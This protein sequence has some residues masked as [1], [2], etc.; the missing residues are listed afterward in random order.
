VQS[1]T[2]RSAALAGLDEPGRPLG[3]AAFGLAPL[4]N[5]AHALLRTATAWPQ[6]NAVQDGRQITNFAELAHRALGIAAALADAGVRP[7]DRVGLYLRRS[8]DAAAAFFGVLAAGAVAVFVNETLRPRQIGY[9]VRHVD[10]QILIAADDLLKRLGQPL[11]VT[12]RLLDIDSLPAGGT[13][14]PVTRVEGDVAQ[15]IF[16]SGSTG[17]PKGVTLSHGNLWAGTRS[18]VAYLGIDR[19]DKVASLLPFSFDYGLN[20]LLCC[21]AT[22]ATLVIERAVVPQRIVQSLRNAEATVLAAVPPLWLQLLDVDDFL[23][24]PLPALRAMTNTGGHLPREAVRKLRAV[25]PQADLVLMYGLTEAFRSCYLAPDR[26][27]RKPGSV[28]NAIPGAEV[29]LL[30]E[31]LEPCAVGETGQLVHRG[32][33]VAMGYWNDPEATAGRFRPNP[34]RAPGAQEAERVVFFRD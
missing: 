3:S 14:T 16:T 24:R 1:H 7:G 30:N 12:A 15:I 19:A 26:V 8:T 18:V 32:P 23:A 22:G 4:G 17:L 34:L 13:W 31:A 6:Q 20:Q 27:D 29:L 11:D 2:T 21:A 33:T 9:I 25:Q 5:F 28:G 10:A